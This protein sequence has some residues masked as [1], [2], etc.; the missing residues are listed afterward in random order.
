MHLIQSWHL[1]QIRG[2]CMY[3][4]TFVCVISDVYIHLHGKILTEVKLEFPR[5]YSQILPLL[6]FISF[7]FPGGPEYGCCLQ[8]DSTL[9]FTR[10]E[11]ARDIGAGKLAEEERQG[12]VECL[13]PRIDLFE[14]SIS[15]WTLSARLLSARGHRVVGVMRLLRGGL[16]PV[17][18]SKRPL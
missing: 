14:M 10:R 7:S 6:S 1:I 13:W 5:R 16:T 8:E 15:L 3:V 9:F 2:T 12:K 18:D 11:N 17:A 4:S